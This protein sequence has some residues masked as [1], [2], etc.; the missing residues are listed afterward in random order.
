MTRYGHDS[1]KSLF[2]AFWLIKLFVYSPACTNSAS[3][4]LRAGWHEDPIRCSH[5]WYEIYQWKL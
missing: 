1:R 4:A 2:G 5:Y 3:F